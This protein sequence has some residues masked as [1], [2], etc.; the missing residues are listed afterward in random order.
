MGIQEVLLHRLGQLE[1]SV[2]DHSEKI[3]VLELAHAKLIG[4]CMGASFAGSALFQLLQWI[5][6]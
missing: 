3:R 5:V 4:V 1:K 2:D 6:K